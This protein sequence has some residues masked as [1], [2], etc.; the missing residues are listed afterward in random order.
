MGGEDEQDDVDELGGRVGRAPGATPCK[1]NGIY[2]TRAVRVTLSR[3]TVQNAR[4]HG[5]HISNADLAAG[6]EAH[7]L[8]IEDSTL[9]GC[10][11]DGAAPR[12][13]NLA[14][15]GVRGLRISDVVSRDSAKAGLKLGGADITF[16]GCRVTGNGNGGVVG[17]P[18]DL[19]GLTIVGDEYSRY[20]N[21]TESA[22]IGGRADGIR[23]VD[24][25]DVTI[26]SATAVGN[27]GSGVTV[28]NGCVDVSVIGGIFDNNGRY[29]AAPSTVEGRCG[30][31]LINNGGTG[32]RNVA[33]RIQ[34]VR[35]GDD[36]AAGSK[37]QACGVLVGGQSDLVEVT[38]SDLRNN[39]DAA[40]VV[41]PE[42]TNVTTS[43]NLE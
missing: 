15:T 41:S 32:N 7:D 37:T 34:D 20:V 23:L 42:A 6:L 9:I 28:L 38:G 13:S 33:I 4:G 19:D 12:G 40:L 35:A 36:R 2:L 31:S 17:E 18:A 11:V 29:D 5:I 26:D 27:D 8:L 16:E 30:I 14:T 3:I 10:G 25:R 22:A 43:D 39:R 24:A 21:W 1:C